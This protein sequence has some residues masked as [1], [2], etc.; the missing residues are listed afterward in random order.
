MNTNGDDD[1]PL[2]SIGTKTKNKKERRRD[3]VM[4][5]KVKFSPSYVDHPLRLG[6]GARMT[7]NVAA[8]AVSTRRRISTQNSHK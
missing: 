7:K 2:L 6:T 4:M 3:G 1:V 5:K 8:R